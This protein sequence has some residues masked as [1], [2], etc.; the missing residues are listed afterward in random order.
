MK[1]IELFPIT[2]FKTKA[3]DNDILKRTLVV[4]ILKNVDDLIIP[5]DWTTNKIITSFSGEPIGR[6]VIK[7]NKNLL[8]RIY[9]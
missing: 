1:S 9:L 3:R 7:K 6:E 2:I 4:D 5:E 8:E